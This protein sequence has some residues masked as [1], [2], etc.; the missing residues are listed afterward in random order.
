MGRKKMQMEEK[1]QALT[2]LEKGDSVIAVARD[3]GVSR[4]AIYQLNRLA[5]LLPHGMIPKRKSGSGA[6]K[7]TSPR[8]DKLLKRE[9]TSYPSITAVKL[10]SKHSE[11]LH[12][13][14]ASTIRHRLQKDLKLPCRRAAKKPM[15]TAAMKKK[16]L[17]FCKKSML[18]S[19]RVEKGDV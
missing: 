12:N 7:K 8:T 19:C 11:L 17:N 3:I 15:L 14:S 1:S 18:D 4:E 6:P 16:R 2:L 13:V 9:V 5:V 10:K